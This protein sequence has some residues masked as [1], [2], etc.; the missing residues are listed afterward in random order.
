MNANTWKLR[1]DLSIPNHIVYIVE[2]Q[3]DL[4]IQAILNK[5]SPTTGARMFAVP[6]TVE[7]VNSTISPL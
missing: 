4:Y 6:T 3:N 2:G 7:F 5:H 1:D